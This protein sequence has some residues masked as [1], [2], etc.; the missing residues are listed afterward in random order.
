MVLGVSSGYSSFV[1]QS[2]DMTAIANLF[3][4]CDIVPCKG[5]ATYPGCAQSVPQIPGDLGLLIPQDLWDKF[6]VSH[7]ESFVQ[8]MDGWMDWQEKSN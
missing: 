8:K 5:L 7:L 4:V 6:Q 3:T 1:P 2:K